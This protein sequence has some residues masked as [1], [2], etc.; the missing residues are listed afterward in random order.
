MS[1]K[2]ASEQWTVR[3]AAGTGISGP[4]TGS[5]RFAPASI[6]WEPTTSQGFWV[7][8]LYADV[9]R[10]EKTLLMKVDP[11]AFS[12]MHSH[13]DELEQLYV[14]Q[15]SFYDQETTMRSGDYCCRAPGAPHEA[16]SEEG[17]IVLL[18]YTRR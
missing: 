6:E 8:S 10:G 9:E 18:V 11:G 15:G 2:T 3:G 5:A 4:I 13:P 14:L 1:E 7:K 12:P 16:G 17:A